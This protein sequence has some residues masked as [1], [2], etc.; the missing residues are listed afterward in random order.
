MERME[1]PAKRRAFLIVERV[2]ASY[3]DV[4]DALCDTPMAS[5]ETT[6]FTRLFC[7][8]PLAVPLSA[9]GLFLPKPADVMLSGETPCWTRKLLTAPARFSDSVWFR[10]EEHTSELQ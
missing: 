4:S 9:T 10:S 7:C 2:T 5:P 1:K 3:C 6:I 8:R